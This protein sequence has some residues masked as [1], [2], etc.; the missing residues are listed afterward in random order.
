MQAHSK[1]QAQ[2]H[3]RQAATRAVA[4]RALG[5]MAPSGGALTNSPLLNSTT[6]SCCSHHSSTPSIPSGAPGKLPPPAAAALP[7]AC[8]PGGGRVAAAARRRAAAA[9][10]CMASSLKHNVWAKSSPGAS[11]AGARCST[12]CSGCR[13]VGQEW[14]AHT[15][16]IVA[17]LAHC[18]RLQMVGSALPARMPSCKTSCDAALPAS[19]QLASSPSTPSVHPG[20]PPSLARP[21]KACVRS[22]TPYRGLAGRRAWQG[23][24]PT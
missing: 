14:W 22:S 9:A 16:V 7:P 11:S 21:A 4:G 24:A 8:R 13:G 20:T 19:Q 3:R 18:L 5:G 2:Q 1:L 23:R 17:V 6:R 10:S 12:P 15:C